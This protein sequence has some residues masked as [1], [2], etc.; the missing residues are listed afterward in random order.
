M[1]FTIGT[2]ST[3]AVVFIDRELVDT[4]TI[5]QIESMSKHNSVSNVRIMPDCH[6]GNGCCVGFTCHLNESV[7]PGLL[8]AFDVMVHC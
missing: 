4:E 2:E 1:P 6:K 3:K 5:K 8:L 7:L